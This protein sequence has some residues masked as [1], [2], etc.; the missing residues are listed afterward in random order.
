MRLQSLGLAFPGKGAGAP[1]EGDLVVHGRGVGR[2]GESIH[3]PIQPQVGRARLERAQGL[4]CLDAGYRG[5]DQAA[6]VC[7]VNLV[8]AVRNQGVIAMAAVTPAEFERQHSVALAELERRRQLYFRGRGRI[9]ITLPKALW[10]AS[11]WSRRP[12]RL[13]PSGVS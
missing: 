9:D 2:A 13:R 3:R 7:R 8:V 4:D 10:S 6:A 11:A 12:E 5:G 1:Q